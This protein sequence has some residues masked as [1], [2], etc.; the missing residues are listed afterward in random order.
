[1]ENESRRQEH[2]NKKQKLAFGLNDR[3]DPKS[4]H[5]LQQNTN[6]V[7]ASL[8]GLNYNIWDTTLVAKACDHLKAR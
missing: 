7:K 8:R 6:Q 5:Q 3:R 1:M 2:A 4:Q